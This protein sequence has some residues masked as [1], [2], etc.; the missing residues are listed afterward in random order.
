MGV[1]RDGGKGTYLDSGETVF[2]RVCESIVLD[3]RPNHHGWILDQ[4]RTDEPGRYFGTLV[5]GE[6]FL[7]DDEFVLAPIVVV[8]FEMRSEE[9]PGFRDEGS[10][11]GRCVVVHDYPAIVVGSRAISSIGNEVTMELDVRC[12]LVGQFGALFSHLLEDRC[13][14]DV[15]G[16]S[17][18]EREIKLR[19]LHEESDDDVRF[20]YK[21]C[22]SSISDCLTILLAD[23]RTRLTELGER[24]GEMQSSERDRIVLLNLCE[25]DDIDSFR[26][27]IKVCFR[28]LIHEP[29]L[30]ASR[31]LGSRGT[32]ICRLTLSAEMRSTCT[33]MYRS[34]PSTSR[35]VST[36]ER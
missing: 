12:S 7:E 2:E 13:H 31:Q 11:P 6:D 15:E 29:L 25:R 4:Y 36:V 17:R 22:F 33:V 32:M 5:E 27:G 3:H 35:R 21:V 8:S 24:R 30:S 18:T 14:V 16:E 23:V 1:W 10:C 34:L 9:L 20:E 19:S 26:R 28:H